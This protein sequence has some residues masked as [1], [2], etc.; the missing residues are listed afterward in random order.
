MEKAIN[1]LSQ[2]IFASAV[3]LSVSI[4]TAASCEHKV[5]VNGQVGTKIQEPV[6]LHT[7]RL[8]GRFNVEIDNR[9]KL[10]LDVGTSEHWIPVEIRHENSACTIYR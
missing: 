8:Y 5:D 6:R 2:S 9:S 10:Q 3:M 4:L 1:S 7:D